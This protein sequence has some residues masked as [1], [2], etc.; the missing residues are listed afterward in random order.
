MWLG[1]SSASS[2]AL[3]TRQQGITIAAYKPPTAR[4][5]PVLPSSIFHIVDRKPTVATRQPKAA[6]SWARRLIGAGMFLGVIIVR[7]C[8]VGYIEKG[9]A[10]AV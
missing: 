8:Y 6:T 9:A 1:Y 5:A 2:Q 10:L 3:S 7:G 4:A